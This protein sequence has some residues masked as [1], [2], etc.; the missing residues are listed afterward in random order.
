MEDNESGAGAFSQKIGTINFY[1][2]NTGF[3]IKLISEQLLPSEAIL[4]PSCHIDVGDK[5][6]KSG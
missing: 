1:F 2:S 6:V 4:M 3:A 5:T